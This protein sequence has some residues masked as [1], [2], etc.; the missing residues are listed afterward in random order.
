M[1]VLSLPWDS[2]YEVNSG[3]PNRF[4]LL[5]CICRLLDLGFAASDTWTEGQRFT[6]SRSPGRVEW[7]WQHTVL[8]YSF[9]WKSGHWWWHSLTWT[10]TVSGWT[11]NSK[12]LWCLWEDKKRQSYKRHNRD[13][14][15][16]VWKF[17][18]PGLK[19]NWA[20]QELERKK[21]VPF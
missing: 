17:I 1:I 16:R 10:Q 3:Q 4:L 12:Q 8:W 2:E 11:L 7:R 20:C 15:S 6:R 14:R 5:N 18:A 13:S 9:I 21:L 19:N